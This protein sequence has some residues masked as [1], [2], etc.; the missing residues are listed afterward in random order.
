MGIKRHGKLNAGNMGM[1]DSSLLL[2]GIMAYDTQQQRNDALRK[3]NDELNLCFQSGLSCCCKNAVK[4]TR[5]PRWFRLLLT[6]ELLSCA[7]RGPNPSAS[8]PTQSI[9]EVEFEWF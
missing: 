3:C 5:L 4:M 9:Q 8:T 2:L 6:L 1:C 7:Y